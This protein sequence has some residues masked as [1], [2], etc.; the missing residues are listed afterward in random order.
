MDIPIENIKTEA[1]TQTRVMINEDTVSE[2]ADAM[3]EGSVFPA[4]TVFHDGTDYFMADGFHRILAAS[5][6]GFENI[7]ADIRKGT[8][9]DALVFAL[10]ANATNGLRRTNLDK[11]RCV[12]IALREFPDWSDRKI[13]ETCGVGNKFVGDTRKQVCSGH[14]SELQTRTGKDGKEYPASKPKEEMPSW[15]APEVSGGNIEQEEI[16]PERKMDIV[17]Q[18]VQTA[19]YQFEKISKRGK[20]YRNALQYMLEWIS[21]RINEYDNSQST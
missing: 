14:T 21:E 9:Q 11:R 19:I 18:Y 4:V 17:M 16:Q 6:C 3:M 1:G 20:D 12:E 10:S 2:Y 8:R 15:T 5:R 13:A 7:S